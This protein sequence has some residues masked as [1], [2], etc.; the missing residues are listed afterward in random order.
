[1]LLILRVDRIIPCN[2]ESDNC[3]LCIAIKSDPD[4][5]TPAASVGVATPP[6]MDPS[7]VIIRVRGAIRALK[8]F[9]I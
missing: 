7:T 8:I 4:A 9:F 3:F 2:F 5:P 6:K 1:M